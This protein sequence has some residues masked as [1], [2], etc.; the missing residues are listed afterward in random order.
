[1]KEETIILASHGTPGARAAE[2]AALNMAKNN[3]YKIIHLYVIPDFWRGMRG[4]DWLNNAITQK[5]FGDYVENELAKEATT[6]VNRLKENAD[7]NGVSIETRATFGKPAES[8]ILL[9]QEVKPSMIFIGTPRPK[10][11]QGYNSRMKLEPL[12]R[13]LTTQLLIVPRNKSTDAV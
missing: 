13:S 4:D 5:T 12:V 1:M 11:E 2:N 8:L 3:N 9:S 7:K 10:G 6:E